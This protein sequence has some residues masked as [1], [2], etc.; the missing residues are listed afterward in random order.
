[1]PEAGP[2]EKPHVLRK[3]MA[4]IPGPFSKCPSNSIVKAHKNGRPLKVVILFHRS[5]S[6]L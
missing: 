2:L 1:M 3:K 6:Y 5:K 4:D